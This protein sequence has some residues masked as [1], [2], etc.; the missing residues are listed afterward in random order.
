MKYN[1]KNRP[2]R[3]VNGSTITVE[4]WEN[5]SVWIF[6]ENAVDWFEG[7]EKELREEIEEIGEEVESEDRTHPQHLFGFW[8]GYA[9]ALKDI[10]G[11]KEG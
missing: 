11:E 4:R 6:Y 5:N 1:L 7:F 10:L 8:S 2:N 9:K 3:K